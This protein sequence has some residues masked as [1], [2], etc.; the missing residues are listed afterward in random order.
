MPKEEDVLQIQV[1]EK[2]LV[3]M[4]VLVQVLLMLVKVGMVVKIYKSKA[5]LYAK[6]ITL[7]LTIVLM[8]MFNT[9]EVVVEL[10]MLQMPKEVT[11]EE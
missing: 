10:V 11:E 5:T 2:D 1:L 4:D 6:R 8:S 3:S 7:K 9:T